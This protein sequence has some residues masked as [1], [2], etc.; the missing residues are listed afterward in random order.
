MR[1]NHPE[2]GLAHPHSIG[3]TI[4]ISRDCPDVVEHGDS[5]KVSHLD[6]LPPETGF[7]LSSDNKTPDRSLRYKNPSNIGLD[8]AKY[9]P[10]VGDPHSDTMEMLDP[11]TVFLDVLADDQ[12]QKMLVMM[13]PMTRN[14]YANSAPIATPCQNT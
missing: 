1:G 13:T 2:N 5:F 11:F 6:H 8:A 9:S 14:M 3:T 12:H 7:G 10:P 4:L